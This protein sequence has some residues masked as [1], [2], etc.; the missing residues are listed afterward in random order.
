M[1]TM[2]N[3]MSPFA[4]KVQTGLTL[5]NYRL[6]ELSSTLG[7]TLIIGQLDGTYKE[8]PAKKLLKRANSISL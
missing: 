2:E 5:A 1:D 4:Q 7:R 8:I 3:R 6:L